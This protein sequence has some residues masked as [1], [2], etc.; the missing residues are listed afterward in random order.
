LGLS[1]KALQLISEKPEL[2]EHRLFDQVIAD[3]VERVDNLIKQGHHPNGTEKVKIDSTAEYT[4]IW[5]Q[6]KIAETW[7]II[8]KFKDLLNSNHDD[9]F[10][11]PGI[12]GNPENIVSFSR[13]IVSLYYRANVLLL[14][15]QSTSV[16]SDC[17]TI[18]KKLGLAVTEI[19][20]K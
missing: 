10:G 18:H 12:P 3:D 16:N 2:W 9:A 11:P 7:A 5:I 6:K 17:E 20:K 19:I 14:S 4:S 8:R 15:I 1:P 13:K